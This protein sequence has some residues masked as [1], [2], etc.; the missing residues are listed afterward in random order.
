VRRGRYN[1]ERPIAEHGADIKLPDLL[2]TLA[3]CEKARS[4]SIYDRC[5][6]L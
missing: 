5:R 1:V 3:H 6:A 4:I 2:V